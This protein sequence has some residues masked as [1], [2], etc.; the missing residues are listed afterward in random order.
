LNEGLEGAETLFEELNR[1]IVGQL[2]GFLDSLMT[3][4][5]LPVRGTTLQ[6]YEIVAISRKDNQNPALHHLLAALQGETRRA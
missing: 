1:A 3:V 2:A 4:D 6:T 5:I